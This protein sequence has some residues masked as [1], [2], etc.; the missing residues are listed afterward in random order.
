M[1]PAPVVPEGDALR[2]AAASFAGVLDAPEADALHAAVCAYVRAQRAQASSAETTL[3][4]VRTIVNEALRG[5]AGVHPHA[6]GGG[7]TD[8]WVRRAVSWCIEEY[9]RPA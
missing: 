9:Y 1:D 8:A 7:A 6:V 2:R 5:H 4:G 3:V